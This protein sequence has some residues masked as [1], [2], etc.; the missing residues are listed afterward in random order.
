VNDWFVWVLLGAHVVLF[1]LV[2]L[3]VMLAPPRGEGKAQ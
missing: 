3:C 1:V 2:T